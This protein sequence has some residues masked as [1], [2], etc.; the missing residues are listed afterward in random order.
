M[1]NV[2]FKLNSAGVRELL[3]SEEMASVCMEHAQRVR[4]SAGQDYET[5][6]RNYPERTGA[7]VRPANTSGYFDNLRNNTL[8]KALL[9]GGK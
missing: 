9:G 6:R 1:S 5:G 8:L 2:I 7:A 3:R 4:E